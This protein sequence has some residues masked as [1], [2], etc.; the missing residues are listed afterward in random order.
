MADVIKLSETGSGD[1]L[2]ALRTEFADELAAVEGV[3]E[4]HLASAAALVPEIG[5]HIIGAGGKRLRPLLTLASAEMAGYRG[6]AHITLAA[7]IEFMHTATLLHDDVVDESDMRRGAA[8]A[9]KLWGNAPSVLVGDFLLG[10][11]FRMMVAA[12][13]M[14]ALDILSQAAATIAEGEVQQLVALRDIHSSEDAYLQIIGAKTATLFAAATEIGGVIAD[15]PETDIEA[16]KSYGRNLGIAFQLIDDALDYG[17]TGQ[18]LGKHT[19]ADFREGKVTLP[20]VLAFRR[21][22]KEQ[23]GFWEAVVARTPQEGDFEHA[24]KLM[25]AT[26]A[27]EDTL[28]RAAHYGARAQ[29]ALALFEDGKTRRLLVDLI[30][31][32]IRRTH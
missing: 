16:L 13:S 6:T 23:R 2:T 15:A 8:T 11:A 18:T 3:F 19:G 10:Q 7:A 26:G 5:T 17:G 29:D 31:F 28:A 12:Q 9:R 22:D 14:R 30:D 1:A 24:V 32:C 20:M 21:G 27:L 4:R 25:H